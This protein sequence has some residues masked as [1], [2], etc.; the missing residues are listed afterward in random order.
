MGELVGRGLIPAGAGSTPGSGIEPPG[1]RGSSPQVRGA[2]DD[3]IVALAGLE[4][5]PRR[6]GE[7]TFVVPMLA[8]ESGS[9][10]QVRGARGVGPVGLS[11]RGLIPAGAGSTAAAGP[12]RRW[13]KAHPRRCGEHAPERAGEILEGGSSPQVRGARPPRRR[14]EPADGLIPAGAGS[15]PP[16]TR[17]FPVTGAHPRRCGEHPVHGP[18]GVGRGGSSPQVRGA[19]CCAAARDSRCGLIPAGAGSTNRVILSYGRHP[20]H[21]R[22]CGEHHGPRRRRRPPTGLIPAGAGSTL[23]ELEC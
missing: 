8:H 22:R 14:H 21:P 11:S 2:P 6:C 4:A 13:P 23:A 3:H 1:P 5:H 16:P 20:A 17:T 12:S 7:H 19:R 10:P 15:T 18:G 9:S